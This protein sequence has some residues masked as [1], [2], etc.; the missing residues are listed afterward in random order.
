VVDALSGCPAGG[1]APP[2][3]RLLEVRLVV[4]SHCVKGT[5]TEDIY[6]DAYDQDVGDAHMNA[7]PHTFHREDCDCS[8]CLLH[9]AEID[10]VTERVTTEALWVF[11]DGTRLSDRRLDGSQSIRG[12]SPS[13]DLDSEL[14]GGEALFF[15]DAGDDNDVLSGVSIQ[16]ALG[17][18][19]PN[20]MRYSSSTEVLEHDYHETVAVIWPMSRSLEVAAGFGQE[21]LLGMLETHTDRPQS[22][23]ALL[24]GVMQAVA[25]DPTCLSFTKR[26]SSGGDYL[27]YR[28]KR[29]THLLRTLESL[30]LTCSSDIDSSTTRQAAV[31][32]ATVE[33]IKQL[34]KHGC[35]ADEIKVTEAVA[36]AANEMKS[37]EVYAALKNLVTAC[38]RNCQLLTPLAIIKSLETRH[39]VNVALATAAFRN[40][41]LAIVCGGAVAHMD[42]RSWRLSAGP[43][44]VN[45][46]SE[47]GAFFVALHRGPEYTRAHVPALIA[48]IIECE[49]DAAT[50][51]M[52]AL[53]ELKYVRD[54]APTSPDLQPLIRARVRY[55]RGLVPPE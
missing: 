48:S 42:T 46:T 1:A 41:L 4:L 21:V 51:N 12:P 38:A 29:C 49:S 23:E 8:T 33:V 24:E 31:V 44:A 47:V 16:E 18:D 45:C 10:A 2:N 37:Q 53:C 20:E 34:T 5:T 27:D 28:G 39:A 7:A 25:G 40:E 14:L 30:H 9:C 54:A 6:D 36:A 11:P 55:L 32:R 13:I 26:A 43:R 15:V 50:E 35:V 19:H 17:H 3:Q 52:Q 22:M